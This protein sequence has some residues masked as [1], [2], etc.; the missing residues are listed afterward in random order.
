M[1][2]PF[3]NN[4]RLKKS[5]IGDKKNVLL[6]LFSFFVTRRSKM[7]Y[8]AV[9]KSNPKFV[10]AKNLIVNKVCQFCICMSHRC[11]HAKIIM[12]THMETDILKDITHKRRKGDKPSWL[13]IIRYKLWQWDQKGRQLF[14]VTT[15]R[16]SMLFISLCFNI[17]SL[18]KAVTY[19]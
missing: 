17:L 3:N 18:K 10:R 7:Y 12:Q 8:Y 14:H 4:C 5:R 19:N 13:P 1:K 6:W 15:L 11:I 2:G 16:M 9:R